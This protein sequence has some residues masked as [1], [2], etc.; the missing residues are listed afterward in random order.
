VSKET[1]DIVRWVGIGVVLLAAYVIIR[2]KV[3]RD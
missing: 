3:T 1:W 2:T